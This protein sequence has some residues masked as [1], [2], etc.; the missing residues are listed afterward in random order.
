MTNAIS[1]L[2][3]GYFPRELPPPFSTLSYATLF[4]R[5]KASFPNVFDKTVKPAVTS[6][7]CPHN[8]ARAGSLRRR[9]SIPNP[10][11]Y[12]QLAVQIESDWTSLHA[13]FT[14]SKLS[15]STPD[16]A[17]AGARA[18]GR[19]HNLDELPT[20][21]AKLRASSR[22]ILSSDISSFYPTIYTHAVP[23]ALSGKAAS[24]KAKTSP[25]LLGNEL[26]RLVRNGQDG[27]TIG[28]PIGP[29]TSLVLAET[30]LAAVDEALLKGGPVNGF[31]YMDDFEF[32]FRTQAEAEQFLARLQ[33]AVHE[34]ELQ[35][36][37]RKTAI[38]PLPE[39]VEPP[40]VSELRTFLFRA[41]SKSQHYDLIRYFNRAFEHRNQTPEQPVLKYA[42][43]RLNATSVDSANWPIFQHLLLQSVSS[44]PGSLP[45]VI[46][47]FK[48]YGDAGYPLDIP[49]LTAAL[50]G[51]IAIHAPLGHGSEVAWAMWGALLF[52]LKIDPTAVAALGSMEDSVVALLSLDA[53]SQGLLGAGF[54]S[55]LWTSL[56]TS[57]ELVD[58]QWLLAYEA[59]VQGWLP[60]AGG[61]DNVSLVPSFSFLKA[62]GVRFYD[63]SVRAS[64]KASRSS[65]TS[66]GGGG[67]YPQ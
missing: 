47:Q 62:E 8:L 16:L 21:R 2:K 67:G 40:W 33:S 35:L 42:V 10:I 36:N 7:A 29:D 11:N 38:S 37:P 51:V 49:T 19:R 3:A 56:M 12:L 17:N 13:H 18:V 27:Q 57:E 58:E 41:G 6:S 20:F 28:I 65:Q 50:S 39:P 59:N 15:L 55:P 44:E 45:F 54:V 30:L 23:W 5:K 26:D 34:V 64:Y 25:S 1:L 22:Y 43:S 4:E 48:F 63:P 9:L 61:K 53:N 60:G 14:K 32:G 24:K 46:E 31:R 52:G 66:G